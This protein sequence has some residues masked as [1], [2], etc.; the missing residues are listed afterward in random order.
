MGR[1]RAVL[2]SRTERLLVLA[3]LAVA[4]GAVPPWFVEN[5]FYDGVTPAVY[6]PG[7][8][9]GLE[10]W[11]GATLPL[12]VLAVGVL[13]VRRGRTGVASSALVGAGAVAVAA[14]TVLRAASASWLLPG[15]G[16]VLTAAAGVA[17]LALAARARTH[18]ER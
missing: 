15:P 16:V 18:P 7:E 5:P 2:W 14:D 13:L 8:R 17:V 4:V 11:G 12:A 10:T 1:V 3:L 9:S 6:Y